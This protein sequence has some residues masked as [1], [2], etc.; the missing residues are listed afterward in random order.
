MLISKC[1]LSKNTLIRRLKVV[2]VCVILCLIRCSLYTLMNRLQKI[3]LTTVTSSYPLL[4]YF[5]A[6][7]KNVFKLK[8]DQERLVVSSD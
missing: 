3:S 6:E 8:I 2:C 1:V 7:A 5:D 4:L